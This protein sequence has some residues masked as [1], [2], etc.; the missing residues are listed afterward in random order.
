[1]SKKL[2][3]MGS[4]SLFLPMVWFYLQVL[5]PKVC[6]LSLSVRQG[7][8]LPSLGHIFPQYFAAVV[9]SSDKKPFDPDFNMAAPKSYKPESQILSSSSSSGPASKP[10]SSGAK[11]IT[12]LSEKDF[13]P[14]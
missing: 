13:P 10:S 2:S 6:S 7:V 4:L 1:M 8:Y 14:L 5:A 3:K 12:N 9:R 11:A